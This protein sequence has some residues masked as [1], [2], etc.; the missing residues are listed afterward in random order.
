MAVRELL[1]DEAAESFN[2]EL[3]AG[4]EGLDNQINRD[5]I[6]MPGLALAGFFEYIH[7]GRIL[8]GFGV[9]LVDAAALLMLVLTGS[10]LYG[11]LMSQRAEPSSEEV[12]PREEP[13]AT[14]NSVYE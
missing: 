8:G 14:P 9:L 10:G 1:S 4:S 5:R 2:L 13:V 3:V 11:W 7:T 6:Q 12:E